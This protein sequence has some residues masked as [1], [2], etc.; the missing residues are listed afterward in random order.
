MCSLKQ[1]D[2]TTNETNKAL[3]RIH[4]LYHNKTA[5]TDSLIMLLLGERNLGPKLLGVFPGGRL[6]QFIEVK[7][8]LK[9][10]IKFVFFQSKTMVQNDLFNPLYIKGIARQLAMINCL[11]AP[12][13]KKSN[14]LIDN[15][16]YFHS[17]LKER[18]QKKDEKAK[19]VIKFIQ[20]HD[21][22]SEIEWIVNN[23]LKIQSPIVFCNNDLIPANILVRNEILEKIKNDESNEK[24][25]DQLIVIIDFEYCSYNFRGCEIGNFFSEHMFQYNTSDPPYFTVDEDKYPN[26]NHQR[27]FINEYLIKLK[28]IKG[29]LSEID[30]VDHIMK[31]VEAYQ[32]GHNLFWTIL[33]LCCADDDVTDPNSFDCWVSEP[34][35]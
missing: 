18:I 3:I 14:W 25:L 29:E 24:L 8:R 4:G 13:N 15:L 34:L 21:F 7:S 16:N 27:N 9:I 5:Q 20:E 31:E 11:D 35:F 1:E 17:I 33:T 12:I 23:V 2:C 19:E 28:Q 10:L 30:T 6:E 26:E 22:D 32:I